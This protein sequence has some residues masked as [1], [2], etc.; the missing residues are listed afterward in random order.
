M[1]EKATSKEITSAPRARYDF[2]QLNTLS[3]V[4]LATSVTGFGAVAGIITG[5]IALAQLKQTKQAGR[6]LAIAGVATGYALIGLAI[7]GSIVRICMMQ[8][9][10][11]D[12]GPGFGGHM[13]NHDGGM[14][15]FGQGQDD[16]GQGQRDGNGMGM[17][18]G[19]MGN[20][21]GFDG[22]QGGLVPVDPNQPIQIPVPSATPMTN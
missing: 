10:G 18:P 3:V 7:V 8:R 14:M 21:M 16:F 13:G 12:F 11:S 5:H 15:G 6:G 20:G 17:G 2:S 1:A 22:G 9:F 19:H 4:S